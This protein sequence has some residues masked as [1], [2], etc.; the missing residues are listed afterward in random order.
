MG[1]AVGHLS[2]GRVLRILALPA[3]LVAVW[4]AWGSTLATTSRVP[5]PSG[6]AAAAW[7]MITSGDLQLAIGVSL[8]RVLLGF[9]LGAG[10]GALLGLAM[11]YLRPVERNV[12]PVVQT[13]RMVAAIALVPLAIIWFGPHG[14]AAVF[15]VAYG[16]FF[17]VVV[18]AVTAV[19]SVDP[20]LIRAAKTMGL[21]TVEIVRQVVMPAGLP[22]LFVGLRLGMGNAWGA[23][24]AAELTVGATAQITVSSG[25]SSTATAASGGIGFLMFY[26][27]DNRVDLS[28]IV[29]AMAAVGMAAS[30]IDRILRFAQYDL[31]PWT[32]YAR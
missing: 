7:E 19:R 15:I 10:A 1:D 22:T 9:G 11:G 14:Q 6:V 25:I 2:L 27:Y 29:V 21:R 20:T 13:F 24:I 8:T 16:S 4:Q 32:R 26:L 30:T 17:P 28:Q 12:D 23:I 31:I 3:A 5:L 18:N